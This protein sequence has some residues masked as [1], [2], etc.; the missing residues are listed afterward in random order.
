MEETNHQD[1]TMEMDNDVENVDENSD[2]EE[3]ENDYDDDQ[4]YGLNNYILQRLKQNDPSI[5]NL[6]INLQDEEYFFSGSINWKDDGDCIANNTHLK[7]LMINYRGRSHKQKY[8]LG[9]E[10]PN[11]PSRQKLQD[12]FSCIYRN[13]SVKNLSLISICI[14]DEFGSSLLEGLQG[15]PSLT[16]LEIG[17]GRVGSSGCI[18]LG[19][20]LAHPNSKLMDIDLPNNHIDDEGLGVLCDGLVGNS[21][22]RKLSLSFNNKITS[23]GWR[24]LSPVLQH[25]NCKLAVI[26]LYNTKINDEGSDILGSSLI[27][28]AVKALKLSYNL[29]ISSAGWQTFFNHLSHSSVESLDLNN[30]KIDDGSVVSL[31]RIG[32]LKSLDL[33]WNKSSVT[34]SGWRSFFNS[35]QIR[36]VHLK[37]LD[38]SGND[39]NDESLGSLLINM[40]SLKTLD[41]GSMSPYSSLRPDSNITPRGWQTLFNSVQDSN[42]DL[43]K[44]NLS[45]NSINDEGMQLLVR[46]LSSMTSL[47]YL[48]LADN[49]LVTPSGWQ[50]LTGYLQSPNFALRELYLNENNINDDTVIAITN[51]LSQNKTLKCLS[52]DDCADEDDNLSITERSWGALSTLLCNKTSIMNT[53][54]SNHTLQ[55]LGCDPTDDLSS[56]LE[57]NKNKDKAEVT[58]QK[59]LHTHFSTNETSKLQ[60]FLDMELKMLPSAIAWIVRPLPIGCK[61]AQVSELSLLYNLTRRLP[62]LFDSMAQNQAKRRKGN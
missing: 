26:D 56:L 40:S 12:F 1:D 11:S 2:V 3:E 61:G 24:A 20:V 36:G 15:H 35:L 29:S 31:A 34:P 47:K 27:G 9:E 7:R 57:L 52:L 4:W 8:I 28:S 22:M 44:L 6:C 17:P 55:N 16:K 46:L 37:K 45:G 54:Y 21:T 10:G 53:F 38:I 48:N 18:A 13:C 23:I 62:D 39:V 49:Q 42:L 25:T 5:T 60:E 43:V 33:C 30:N 14:N 51:T 19:K 32:T 41:M 59:I 58:R 50:A